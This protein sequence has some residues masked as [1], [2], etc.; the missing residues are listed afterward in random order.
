MACSGAAGQQVAHN[1]LGLLGMLAR[2]MHFKQQRVMMTVGWAVCKQHRPQ[3]V[4]DGGRLEACEP[5]CTSPLRQPAPK[6]DAQYGTRLTM[7]QEDLFV[8]STADQ[9]RGQV[10]LKEYNLGDQLPSHDVIPNKHGT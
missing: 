6:E 7:A 8:P 1:T 9:R 5:R 3:R 4:F 2:A 10:L